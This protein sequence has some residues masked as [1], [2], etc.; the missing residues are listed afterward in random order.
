MN[1]RQ[2]LF[3]HAL[4]LHQSGRLQEAL[5]LYNKV[6]PWQPNNAR[7]LDLV[8][9]ANLQN[10]QMER[11]I[12]LIQR[13]LTLNPRNPLAHIN[14][15]V[16]QQ[17]LERLDE[18]LASYDKALALNPDYADA[19]Y[20]RGRALQELKRLDE[21]LA[22]YDKAL[23]INPGHASAYNNQG[24]AL[25]ELRRLDDALASYDKALAINP[26]YADAYFNRGVAMQE[27]K[28]LDEALASYDKALAINP[29]HA[30]AYCGRGSAQHE[31]MR[32]DEALASYDNAIANKHDHAKAHFNKSMALLV[33]GD[34]DRGWELYEWRFKQ[35]TLRNVSQFSQRHWLGAESL[36]GKT[37]LLH[38]EQGLGDTIQFCRYTK[39]VCDLGA[40]VFL[41]VQKP[42]IGL[43][44]GLEGVAA[45]IEQ[46]QPRPA[47]DHHCPLLSL[48]LALKK[49]V[50][51]IPYPM[52]YL[53]ADEDKVHYWQLRIGSRPR[54]KV[55]LVWSGGLRPD[56]PESWAVNE[57]RNIPLE[58]FSRGLNSVNADFFSLQKGEQAEAELRLRHQDYWPREQFY[59]FADE[60]RDFS[61]TAALIANLD[62][63]V[64][65]DTSTAHL[66]AALGKPTWILNR[67]D[68]CWRWLLERDDSPWYQSVK[69]YR[70]AEDQ[71]WQ[72]VLRRV[73]SDLTKLVW[74]RSLPM[75]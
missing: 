59:N 27:L 2:N 21:A 72:P 47:F 7:L 12:E 29:G 48:P 57:R 25:R 20:N 16:A 63:I 31:L 55:G 52:R 54:L 71:L 11:G 67:F 15:G 39:P 5:D 64:C 33:N 50:T 10:G 73:A 8:G 62:V 28:R 43:L 34:F 70:Q 58:V 9:T 46:G 26:D 68:T 19:Y 75:A 65:V 22:S 61:D 18:A 38:A 69:L 36:E 56:Q 49:K 17:K 51:S 45:V 30:D 13:S 6:L 40:K 4:Q 44:R 42:L 32:L 23:A 66:S 3:N 35:A 37:I 74:T 14:I 1:E 60:I 41:E 24:V 53:R